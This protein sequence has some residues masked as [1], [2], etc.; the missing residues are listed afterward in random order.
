MIIQNNSQAELEN[1]YCW[2]Y[3]KQEM[4]KSLPS[5]QRSSKFSLKHYKRLKNLY[6]DFNKIESELNQPTEFITNVFN[7]NFKSQFLEHI[8]DVNIKYYGEFRGKAREG[9]GLNIW[10]NGDRYEGLWANDMQ[11]S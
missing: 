8:Y 5:E 4:L 1:G 11:N 3:Y 2:L 10:E 6:D 9:K 7:E